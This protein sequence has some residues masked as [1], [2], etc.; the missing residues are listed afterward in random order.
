[1]RRV[2]ATEIIEENNIKGNKIYVSITPEYA[3]LIH[4]VLGME[5]SGPVMAQWQEWDLSLVWF[6]RP[7]TPSLWELQVSQ[8][9]LL[10][11][12]HV[13]VIYIK[14]KLPHKML[15]PPN[16][17]VEHYCDHWGP[18]CSYSRNTQKSSFQTFF[19][20]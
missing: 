13:L 14:R 1:M 18:L 3:N 7:S 17:L 11:D 6:T 15:L 8:Y 20:R 2:K 12:V 5:E 19:Q 16:Y 10:Q 9:I 4:Q